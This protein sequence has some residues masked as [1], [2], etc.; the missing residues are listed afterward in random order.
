M[1]KKKKDQTTFQLRGDKPYTG[2][3]AEDWPDVPWARN[4]NVPPWYVEGRMSIEEWQKVAEEVR[5]LDSQRY[6][7]CVQLL[8]EHFGIDMTAPDADRRLVMALACKHVPAFQSYMSVKRGQASRRT[9]GAPTTLQDVAGI[10][11]FM[12]EAQ[13]FRERVRREKGKW[14]SQRQIADHL[15]GL[16]LCKERG[17]TYET[18]RNYLKEIKTAKVDYIK[19]NASEFQRQVMENVV[20]LVWDEINKQ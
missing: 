8:Y 1:V 9:G 3:L 17:I 5:A 20:P 14:P 10:T 7:S 6:L 11:I 2:L 13:K 16:P 4:G 15:R 18:A 12:V 19:G